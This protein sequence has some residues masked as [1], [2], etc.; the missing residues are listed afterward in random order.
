MKSSEGS[1]RPDVPADEA[2]DKAIEVL[3]QAARQLA[4]GERQGPVQ[5]DDTLS[6]VR[7]QSLQREGAR[8]Q[9]ARRVRAVAAGLVA[10]VLVAGLAGGR[11]WS[12]RNRPID[13]RLEGQLA[14]GEG[15]YI[16]DVAAGGGRLRFSEG[17]NIVLDPGT[18]AWVVA[19]GPHGAR[20]RLEAGSAHFDVVHR[21]ASNWAIDAGPFAILVTGTNFDVRWNGA[22]EQLQVVLNRGEVNVRGPLPG[23]GVVLRPGQRLVAQARQGQTPQ[24]RIEDPSTAS[25]ATAPPTP[26][27]SPQPVSSSPAS[28]GALRPALPSRRS[29]PLR[30]AMNEVPAAAPRPEPMSWGKRV[31]AGDF[32]GVLA[33]ADQYGLEACATGCRIEALVA[34]ADAARYLG[35]DDLARRMLLA[36]RQRFPGS[37]AAR[38][39]AFLLARLA[40]AATPGDPGGRAA[41][42]RAAISWYDRYLNESPDGAYAAEALGRKMLAVETLSDHAMARNIALEYVHR[43]PNGS[44]LPQATALLNHP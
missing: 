27:S 22:D 41:L 34:L 6:P 24:M 20:L 39:A 19:R 8:R 11:L 29:K 33:E 7:W 3:S 18:R 43:F 26:A 37:S 35:K 4:Q 15:G 30:A 23:G 17:T 31:A 25:S 28:L 36:Q 42:T 1:S 9:R 40:D 44:Y 32:T 5:G 14:V 16:H 13:Y 38:A 12:G 21:P 10:V 2:V